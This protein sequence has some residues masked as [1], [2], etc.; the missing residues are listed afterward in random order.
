VLDFDR[1]LERRLAWDDSC[2]WSSL[3]KWS[4][5]DIEAAVNIAETVRLRLRE[6]HEEDASFILEVL[7]D[8]QFVA[9]V[10]DRGVHDVAAARRYITDG[11]LASYRSHGFGLYLVELRSNAAQLGICGLLRRDSHPDVEMGFAFMPRARGQGYALEAAQATLDFALHVLGLTRIVALTAPQNQR[12]IRILAHLG[13]RC[14][15]TVRLAADGPDWLL[16]A[17]SEVR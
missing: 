17:F 4:R 14:E 9:N 8:P 13:F 5:R 2:V 1:G 6:M 7:T 12:S 10:G 11:V 3:A 16:L 15:R